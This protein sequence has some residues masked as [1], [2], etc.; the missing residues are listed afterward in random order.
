[1]DLTALISEH[2]IYAG[3]FLYCLISGVVPVLNTE[4]F[5]VGVSLLAPRAN[6]YAVWGLATAGHLGG[7]VLLY[8]VGQGAIHI[9]SRRIHRSL[10]KIRNKFSDF[11]RGVAATVFL[12]A[13]IAV[14]PFYPVTLLAGSVGVSLATYLLPAAVGLAARFGLLLFFP[15]AV[16]AIF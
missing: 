6:L 8:F 1:L 11:K 13:F 7:K 2:G 5:L 9:P 16:K 15:Q 14:P 3:T 4:A 12:S 10:E